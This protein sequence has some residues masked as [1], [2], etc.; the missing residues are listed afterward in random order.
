[1][2]LIRQKQYTP[3]NF[4]EIM[5][6]M[7]EMISSGI[8]LKRQQDLQNSADTLAQ[9]NKGL[10]ANRALLE[11]GLADPGFARKLNDAGAFNG[12]GID[13]SI[14]QASL[15]SGPEAT[16]GAIGAIGSA[17]TEQDIPNPQEAYAKAGGD[18][19]S[20]A[21]RPSYLPS[22][23]DAQTGQPT[24]PS[25]QLKYSVPMDIEQVKQAANQRQQALRGIDSYKLGQQPITVPGVGP[26]GVKNN[27]FTTQGSAQAM[28]SV[29]M[30]PTPQQIISNQNAITLGT[31]APNAIAAGAKAGA[32][33]DQQQ[34]AEY[35]PW[36]IKARVDE[37]YQKAQNAASAELG[38]EGNLQKMKNLDALH[39]ASDPIQMMGFEQDQLVEKVLKGVNPSSLGTRAMNATAAYTGINTDTKRMNDIGKAGGLEMTHIIGNTGITTDVDAAKGETYF[40]QGG[41]SYEMAKKKMI[42]RNDLIEVIPQAIAELPYN[43]TPQQRTAKIHELMMSRH[44][45]MANYYNQIFTPNVQG[46][47]SAPQVQN[48]P[49]K[50]T[51]SIVGQ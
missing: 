4:D 17:K 2:P 6:P 29:P 40:A 21:M 37:A 12:S 51:G 41:D 1:M 15:N 23:P 24:L 14:I 32:E 25:S 27:T 49:R 16:Q 13:P 33:K 46:G 8:L 11:K 5:K 10:D 26:D 36:A 18:L 31:A 34:R 9:K 3:I 35:A 50:L 43:A 38:K 42:A 45:D 20:M 7:Q 30:E 47:V 39:K 28:G 22:Q 44:P 19:G 48:G